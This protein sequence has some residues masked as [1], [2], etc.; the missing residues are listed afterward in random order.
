METTN[1][2]TNLIDSLMT[3]PNFG[4]VL[5]VKKGHAVVMTFTVIVTEIKIAESSF[6]AAIVWISFSRQVRTT[7]VVTLVLHIFAV[8]A[9]K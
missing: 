3:I 2:T 4:T 6:V 5:L 7:K 8:I 9:C 1:T